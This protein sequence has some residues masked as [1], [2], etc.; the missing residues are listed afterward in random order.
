MRKF[1]VAFIVGCTFAPAASARDIF[2]NNEIGDD[3]FDGS[4]QEVVS[5]R[6]GPTRTIA[7][8]L[9][10]ANTGDHIHIANTGEPYRESITMQGGRHSGSERAPF[11]VFGNGAVLDGAIPIPTGAWEHYRDSVF[12]FR[13]RRLH[14]QQLFLDGKPLVSHPVD[15]QTLKIPDLQPLEWTRWNGHIYFRVEKDRLP[16]SYALTHAGEPTGLTIYQV[17]D[18]AVFDL[19]VQGF[20]ADGVNVHDAFGPSRLAGLTCRGNGRSGIAVVGASR[21]Q[22]E[23]CLLGENGDSQLLLEGLTETYI[24]D[25]DLLEDSAPAYRRKSGKLFIDGEPAE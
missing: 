13:P 10:V 12:R 16:E 4:T 20:S 5:E 22:I 9:R 11:A 7:K 6:A 15:Q 2:V 25:S 18:V 19:V 21:V 14:Y 17:R 24:V 3:L 1:I 23:G 8:A